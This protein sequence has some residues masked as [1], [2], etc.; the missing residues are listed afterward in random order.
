MA[1][2]LPKL[3]IVAGPTASGKTSFALALAQHLNAELINADSRQVV[4]GLDI[5]TNKESLT[6]TGK[7]LDSDGRILRQFTVDDSQ[8]RG[9]LYNIVSPDQKYD[10]QQFIT[11]AESVIGS[12]AAEHNLIVCGGTGLY[13]DA[14]V[15]GYRL[16]DAVPDTGLRK[17]LSGLNVS[18]LQNELKTVDPQALAASNDSDRV[19]PVRL[20]RLIE[21]A[22]KTELPPAAKYQT[23]LLYPDYNRDDLFRT[24]ETRAEKMFEQGFVS[25]VERLVS[26]GYADSPYLQGIGYRQVMSY[27]AGDLS[28]DE[29][30]EQTA[31]AHR[32]YAT[33]QITWFESAGRGYKLRRVQFTMAPERYLISE[34]KQWFDE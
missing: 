19:N 9:W 23:V 17:R 24:I 1:A 25:E 22:G 18:E 21:K 31:V 26:E 29:M 34:L 13:I 32:Q 4:S 20:I 11:D 2:Q 3:I 8:T 7:T 30:R 16:A 10:L 27:L 15:K 28:Y 5:G 12:V 14:L 33:R 6:A